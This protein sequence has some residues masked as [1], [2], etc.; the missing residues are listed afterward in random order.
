ML[1]QIRY[2][3]LASAVVASTFVA[4]GAQAA[5]WIVGLVGGNTLV[6][7]DPA[8]RKVATKVDIKGANGS[9]VGFDVRPA[10]GMLYVI[11]SERD[12]GHHRP[13]IRPGPQEEQAQP[14]LEGR[15][16]HHRFQPGG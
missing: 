14:A 15:H 9:V 12:G 13:Q 4:S 7:I 5:G 10:D 6:T 11:T 8:T 1:N 16:H 2:L 3:T